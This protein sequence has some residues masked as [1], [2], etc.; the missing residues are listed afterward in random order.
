MCL[1]RQV[2]PRIQKGHENLIHHI[3]VYKCADVDRKFLGIEYE[4]YMQPNTQL[5][6]CSAIMFGW[7]FSGVSR[8]ACVI[9]SI[10]FG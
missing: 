5:Y 4:C 7:E 2:E 6:P 8:P 10:C 1:C 3:I 9:V